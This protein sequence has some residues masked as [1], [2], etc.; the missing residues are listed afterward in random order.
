[1]NTH[2]CELLFRSFSDLVLS[3]ED[4][5][6]QVPRTMG[7][8]ACFT[9]TGEWDESGWETNL[10]LIIRDSIGKGL[11]NSAVKNSCFTLFN[12]AAEHSI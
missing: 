8:T 11:R 2:W 1:M 6:K 12:P 9:V 10:E 4:C 5:S 7:H 3:G